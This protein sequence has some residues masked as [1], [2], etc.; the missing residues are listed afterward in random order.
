MK[1]TI[2]HRMLALSALSL[3][4]LAVVG[5]AGW[6]GTRRILTTSRGITRTAIGMR[7]HLEADMMHHALRADVLASLT[8]TTSGDRERVVHDVE[9]HTARFRRAMAESRSKDRTPEVRQALDEV[10]PALESYTAD[11]GEIVTLATRGETAAARMRLDGFL[12]RFYAL[13][14]SMSRISDLLAAEATAAQKEAD[15]VGTWNTTA[16]LVIPVV[17]VF[18]LLAAGLLVTRRFVQPIEEA[19]RTLHRV[20]SGDLTARMTVRG[21]DELG[22]MAEAVN[23][24]SQGMASALSSIARNAVAL[25]NASEELSTVAHQLT[26]NSR[27]TST[28]T[29]VASTA[30][31]QVNANVRLVAA[32]AQEVG[33]SIREVANSAQEAAGVAQTAV[34]VAG[35]ADQTVHQLGESSA[36]IGNV[37]KVISAIAGQTNILALNAEIEAARAGEAGKGFAVVANEVKELAKETARAT[38]DIA[39]RVDTIQKDSQAAVIALREIVEIIDRISATQTT[40]ATAVE[41]Q[42]AATAGIT[43]NMSEAA[44][45]TGEIAET[46]SAVAHAAESTSGGAK[47]TQQAAGELAR[48]ASELQRLVARFQFEDGPAVEFGPRRTAT[49]K[50]YSLDDD[51]AL[52]LDRAA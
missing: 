2:K 27:E 50:A 15:A 4:L 38:E 46:I 43:R 48:M 49:A 32:S 1:W 31:E 9:D 19:V 6:V 35:R 24:A 3:A 17:A 16:N 52:G 20:A 36:Q 23:R 21:R 29:V 11:A 8:A 42:S 12:A 22:Q 41:E 30:S 10:R 28:Q 25:G 34:R 13:E 14:T 40:I 39:E 33:T 51:G 45:G 47:E 7:N 44:R 18:V 26:A 37:V 5:L